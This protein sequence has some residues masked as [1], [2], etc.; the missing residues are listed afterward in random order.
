MAGTGAVVLCGF[1]GEDPQGWDICLPP[2]F[3]EAEP[4]TPL[5]EAL[6]I[7]GEHSLHP[8]LGRQ[9]CC[10]LALQGQVW[11]RLRFACWIQQGI[12]SGDAAML[13]NPR[14]QA[15]AVEPMFEGESNKN[16]KK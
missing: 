4:C 15:L 9:G 2:A 7:P 13:V 10:G 12:G 5:G 16:H 14:L 6:P 3:Q 8:G 1:S 11:S